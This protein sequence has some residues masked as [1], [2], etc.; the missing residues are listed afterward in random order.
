MV[1]PARLSRANL[2]ACPLPR[3]RTPSSS[4]HMRARADERVS[5]LMAIAPRTPRSQ[6]LLLIAFWQRGAGSTYADLG[7]R[8]ICGRVRCFRTISITR[9]LRAAR[10]GL[11]RIVPSCRECC[12]NASS[13]RSTGDRAQC[14]VAEPTEA[15]LARLPRG[16][17]VSRRRYC[18]PIANRTSRENAC[19]RCV[20]RRVGAALTLR[21]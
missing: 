5:Q 10:R 14:A 20:D 16:D 21:H 13:R 8:P 12:R 19:A 1:S 17:T 4:A 11:S 3:L 6:R 15:V 2:S 18:R 7:A 9:H